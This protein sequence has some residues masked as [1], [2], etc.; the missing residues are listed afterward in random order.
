MTTTNRN[1]N[2]RRILATVAAGA[3]LG[4]ATLGIS[5][6]PGRT[7]DGVSSSP[8]RSAAKS[9]VQQ[10]RDAQNQQTIRNFSVRKAGGG[11][12]EYL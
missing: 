3:A 2:L 10:T 7:A 8:G 5:T 6:S 11:S 1:H 9:N 4:A 12:L